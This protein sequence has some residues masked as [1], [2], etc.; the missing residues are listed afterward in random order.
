[1]G[2]IFLVA[3]GLFLLVYAG[4][5]KQGN[6]TLKILIFFIHVVSLLVKQ[7]DRS[8]LAIVNVVTLEPEQ[9][10]DV[11]NYTRPTDCYYGAFS[12]EKLFIAKMVLVACIIVTVILAAV[13]QLA[14]IRMF[15][16]ESFSYYQLSILAFVPNL[17]DR[18]CTAAYTAYETVR[19]RATRAY[20]GSAVYE[21][22]IKPREL[23]RAVERGDSAGT[24]RE[25][26]LVVI[27]DGKVR[28]F[29]KSKIAH[30]MDADDRQREQ[31]QRRRRR[32]SRDHQGRDEEEGGPE[33]DG[34][35]AA[36]TD[37][38]APPPRRPTRLTEV[39]SKKYTAAGLG[40]DPRGEARVHP[41]ADRAGALVR[42]MRRAPPAA[43][44]SGSP[45]R[46]ANGAEQGPPAARPQPLE[47]EA[48]T[49]PRVRAAFETY[50]NVVNATEKIMSGGHRER[51]AGSE[52][53]SL[54]ARRRR[55]ELH[56]DDRLAYF[57]V[58][59]ILD[60]VPYLMHRAYRLVVG[61]FSGPNESERSFWATMT[62]G[63]R[64]SG[65][66][67]KRVA[68]TFSNMMANTYTYLFFPVVKLALQV[69]TCR[70][71]MVNGRREMRLVY[72]T[73]VVCERSLFSDSKPEND[74]RPVFILACAMLLVLFAFT[75]SIFNA[76]QSMI[77]AREAALEE[78]RRKS[79]G[80]RIRHWMSM[81]QRF[82]SITLRY[83][84]G[85]W[86]T[87]MY[88]VELLRDLM[89]AAVFTSLHAQQA[90]IF[91]AA[92]VIAI[93]GLQHCLV[94]PY[95]ETQDN[96]LM[97]L[98]YFSLL[99]ICFCLE[100]ESM[101]LENAFFVGQFLF[102]L[103]IAI[104]ASFVYFCSSFE[105]FRG[106]MEIMNTYRG[107]ADRLRRRNYNIVMK[108]H[109]DLRC[110]VSWS[111]DFASRIE[112]NM[113]VLA[114]AWGSPVNE[115][116]CFSHKVIRRAQLK[117][118]GRHAEADA[119]A[120]QL[121]SLGYVY[122]EFQLDILTCSDDVAYAHA[123]GPMAQGADAVVHL[124]RPPHA[125]PSRP[126]T[127]ACGSEDDRA[128]GQWRRVYP[129][130]GLLR[131]GVEYGSSSSCTFKRMF[132]GVRKGTY[133]LRLRV[134]EIVPQDLGLGLAGFGDEEHADDEARRGIEPTLI[135]Q[136][137]FEFDLESFSSCEVSRKLPQIHFSDAFVDVESD[138]GSSG[139]VFDVVQMKTVN[140]EGMTQ[141]TVV[142]HEREESEP[143]PTPIASPA[144]GFG[145]ASLADRGAAAAA[146]GL[147]L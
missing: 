127:P 2:V 13:G 27:H 102:Y 120:I 36:A 34:E 107:Y 109:P 69:L 83:K 26:S 105:R 104:A 40:G 101:S 82:G 121:G 81:Q 112:Q 130:A 15:S 9:T 44:A 31:Q 42:Y 86:Y 5:S 100:A 70:E 94:W 51:E 93:F 57:A 22:I 122:H 72:A 74:H 76:I 14:F 67:K 140:L 128:G 138:A 41:I 135:Q 115:L 106:L 12:A 25:P 48:E 58:A 111:I 53:S 47:E 126:A 119:I 65:R 90:R 139:R 129:N 19:G 8:L 71:V 46:R 147:A 108:V 52:G 18:L 96:L 16:Y 131:Q 77:K 145:G 110:T 123:D 143:R 134:F 17:V 38:R 35:G 33:D 113:S 141:D 1:M 62:I 95:V 97:G 61:L 59:T 118:K 32:T 99:I 73:E 49:V 75:C 21:R 23:R 30:I 91:A 125:D 117:R 88:F 64:D 54:S 84:P 116:F 50:S 56:K 146:E 92:W 7:V 11:E 20:R 60:G 55:S 28:R 87:N 68:A 66:D 43:A 89:I 6:G 24:G 79:D 37:R 133:I 39:L 142:F 132:R 137:F 10:G 144:A 136:T 3:F 103:F 4:E 85:Y 78:R 29:V 124:A 45:H 80:A 98:A 63:Q 114:P